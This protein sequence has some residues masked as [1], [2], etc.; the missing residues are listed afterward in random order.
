MEKGK[1][2]D[3]GL[4]KI[5]AGNQAKKPADNG[6][7]SSFMGLVSKGSFRVLSSA[8]RGSGRVAD[9]DW[10]KESSSQLDIC[11]S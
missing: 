1:E 4:S 3:K 2:E 9:A 7:S 8:A 6:S 5:T 11:T 10:H